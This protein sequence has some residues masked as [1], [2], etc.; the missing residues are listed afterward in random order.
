MEDL[1]DLS[2]SCRIT[3][4]CDTVIIWPQDEQK[5]SYMKF[6]YYKKGKIGVQNFRVLIQYSVKY[7]P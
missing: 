1:V 5:C 4:L 3:Q 2:V 6:S 7:F